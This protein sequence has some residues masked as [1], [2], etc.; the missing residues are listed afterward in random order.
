MHSLPTAARVYVAAIYLGGILATYGMCRA[1]LPAIP[2]TVWQIVF[3][4]MLSIAAAGAKLRLTRSRGADATS[5][6]LDFVLVFAVLSLFGQAAAMFISTFSCAWA[7]LTPRRQRPFQFAF[8]I[9]LNLITWFLIG[10]VYTRLNGNSLALHLNVHLAVSEPAHRSLLQLL[11][12][13]ATECRTIFA[14]AAAAVTGFLVPSFGVAVILG[15]KSGKPLLSFWRETYGWTLPGFFAMAAVGTLAAWLF[16]QH[17]AVLLI[18]AIPVAVQTYLHW[19]NL[20]T[21]GEEREK[22]LQESQQLVEELRARQEDLK[23][24][25]H[26]TIQTLALAIDAKDPYT[27]QH[28]GRVQKYAVATARELKVSPQELEAIVTGAALHDI[29]KLGVPEHILCKPGRLTEEEFEKMKQHTEI[30]AAILDP[31]EFP[32]PV[33]EAV[34]SHHEKWNGTGYPE[35]LKGESIP[36]SARVLAVADVYDAL[37][38]N[39][40]YRA[41]WPHDRALAF[42]QEESGS[43]FD[44]TV[45]QAFVR[46]IT[47]LVEEMALNGEGPFAVGGDEEPTNISHAAHRIHRAAYELWTLYEVAQTLSSSLGMQDTL[48][49]LARKLEQV[50]PDTACL[51]LVK[52]KEADGLMVRSAVGVDHEFFEGCGTLNAESRSLRVAQ[53]QTGWLGN[54]DQDDLLINSSQTACW[55]D[56]H[57][58]M[59]VPIVHEKS[60]LGTINV[61]HKQYDAFSTEDLHLLETIASRVGLALYNAIQYDRSHTDAMTD[62]VTE[63]Y[64]IRYLTQYI[65]QRCADVR[66]R[67]QI[68]PSGEQSALVMERTPLY[69]PEETLERFYCRATDTFALLCIDVDNFK[70][71][72]DV[73]GHLKGDRVLCA[74]SQLFKKTVRQA[75]IVARYGG[76]EFLI[77]LDGA[78]PVEAGCL[79]ARIQSAVENYDPELSYTQ[80][81]IRLGA[82]VGYACFPYDGQDGAALLHVA[83]IRMYQNKNDRKLLRMINSGDSPGAPLQNNTILRLPHAG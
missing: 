5:T 25:Y 18:V 78:G 23:R 3:F 32:W 49:I 22:H 19:S 63:L 1:G 41:A 72:N 26:A 73:F 37:T 50:F 16:A 14:V 2:M 33:R 76:D 30:G 56:L 20:I 71:I 12:N 53:S 44:P 4:C 61:Y 68:T 17:V 35:G 24:V 36:L 59:I 39:R 21:S 58:A 82:S 79:A 45:V 81:T 65:E 75:D 51:F 27:H 52:E 31:V 15:L 80:G 60:V 38:S 28:I 9:A 69:N 77:L 8:N 29:G 70:G 48:Q 46:V 74:L 66:S 67:Q 6:Y 43:H 64:N 40:A 55:V 7:C 13:L 34:K 54:Y 83:D 47:P 62:P 10:L 57:A 42:I 11:G